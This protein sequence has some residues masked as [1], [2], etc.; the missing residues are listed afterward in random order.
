MKRTVGSHEHNSQI[1]VNK[2]HGGTGGT[3]QIREDFGMPRIF[4]ARRCQRFLMDWCRND[5]ADTFLSCQIYGGTNVIKGGLPAGC[6]NDTKPWI[7]ERIPNYQNLDLIATARCS[8]Y[9]IK[10]DNVKI[11]TKFPCCFF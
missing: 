9:V 3:T 2:H 11:N 6:I 7:F 5:S 8:L 4:D 1:F 10:G